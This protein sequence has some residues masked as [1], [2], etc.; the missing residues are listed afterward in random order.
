MFDKS[1]ILARLQNG[2]TMDEIAKEMSEAL[3]AAQQQYQEETIKANAEKLEAERVMN[4]KRV[5]VDMILDGLCDYLV[6]VG[7]EELLED[8]KD[9]DTDEVIE[10]LDSIVAFAK[11][12]EALKGLEFPL[13]P[14]A[15]RDCGNGNDMPKV[16][17]KVVD[18]T[19]ADMIIKSF[20]KGI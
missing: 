6:A 11:S 3:N 8:L 10:A 9:I 5:A 16:S 4:A 7:D 14:I 1:E 2:D 13:A 12:L 19:N 18:P 15:K 17:V 20:L